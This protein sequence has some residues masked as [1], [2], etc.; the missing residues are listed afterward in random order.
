VTSGAAAAALQRNATPIVNVVR[1][2]APQSYQFALAML[3]AKNTE[4]AAWREFA[5]AAQR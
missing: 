1:V 4:S 5:D 3:S 2:I